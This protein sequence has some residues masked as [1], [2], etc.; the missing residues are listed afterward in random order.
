MKKRVKSIEARDGCL[1]GGGRM[2]ALMRSL[3]WSTTSIGPVENWSAALRMMVRLIL[4]NRLQM[5]LW[6]GPGFCQIYN[7]AAWPALG[8]KHPRS[9]GQPAS[10]CWA[11]IWHII[12]PLI[13]APFKGGEATWMDDIFLEINR[14]GFKEET[15]WTIAYSPV[16]DD[17]APGGIGG[18]IGT[19]NEITGKVLGER[20]IALLRDLGAR[21]SEAKTA[22]EAC[23]VAAQSLDRHRE[24]VPFG[25]IYLIGDDGNT[26]MLAGAS[27]ISANDAA[28][29]HTIDLEA[30][31]SSTQP[32]PLAAS[33]RSEA[34]QLVDDLPARLDGVPP[35]P[36]SDP[37]T[38]AV[39]SPIRSNIAHRLAGVLVL[40]VSARLI[41]DDH[42]RGFFELL[43]SQVANAIANARAYEEE[44]KR[45]EA[46]AEIDRAKTAFFSNVS[47]EFRTPLTLMLGPIEDM[48]SRLGPREEVP[49]DREELDL[50]HRN[51]RRLLKLV[52]TLLDFSRTEA[53]R[54]HAAFEPIDL[55]EL[56]GELASVFRPAI[57]KA[58]LRFIVDCQPLE[59]AVH[60]DRSMWE[61]IA[62]NLLSNAF[63]FT[64]EGE[65][66]LSLRHAGEGVEL[67][68]RDTG[69]GIAEHELP[70]IFDR[71]HR[72]E[73]ARGRTLE[74]SGIGLALVQE[75]AKLHRGTVR[76]ESTPGV[77]SRFTVAVPYGAAD[78]AA[79]AGPQ[80]TSTATGARAYVGEAL[81]WLP[82][83]LR[84]GS[85][86]VAAK[87]PR[88]A[89]RILLA[90]DNADLRP[91][92]ERLLRPTYRVDTA[93]DGE[94]A[95]AAARDDPPDLVLADVM[96]P[97]LD[98]FGLL[99]ALRADPRTRDV[100]LI[101][102]YARAGEESRVDGLAAGANDYLIKPFTARE[103]LAR[104]HSA[105]S[106]AQASRAT[107][108]LERSMRKSAEDARTRTGEELAS[109]LA[110]M[111]RLHELSTRL[112]ADTEL[113]P[114]LEEVLAATIE[115][116]TAD[117]GMVQLYDPKNRL[118]TLV[119]QRGF[120]IELAE[121]F[122]HVDENS[123]TSCG[124]AMN[125]RKRVIIE[126]VLTD[127]AYEPLR[128]VAAEAG[129]RAIQSTPLFSRGGELLGVISTHFVR[130]HRP[131]VRELT[132]TDLYARHAADAIDRKRAQEVLRSSEERFRRYFELG[133]IGMAI[134][135][136]AKGIVEVN[137]ELCN[138]LGYERHELMR[139]T[140]TEMTHPDDLAADVGQFTRVLDGEIDGYTLDK[141][142]I[143]KD[144]CVIHSITAAKC[145]RRHDGTVDYFVG[146][147]QDITE[148]KSAVEDRRRAEEALAGARVDLA[149]IMRVTTMGELVASIAHEINQPLGAIATSGHAGMRWLAAQPPN[150]HEAGESLG[151]IVRDASR[152]ANV[153][154]RIR[155]FLQREPMQCSPIDIVDTIDE[156]VAFLQGAIM[157][158]G[159]SLSITHAPR[160]R[161][162]M[163]DRVQLQ[164]VIVNLVMN[165]IESM[166]GV[167]DRARVL[168]IAATHHDGAML[169]VSVRDSGVGIEHH[170][171]HRIFDAFYTSKAN[172]MGMGLA[173]SRSIIEAHGGRLWLS[174]NAGPG[175]TFQFTLPVAD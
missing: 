56:T 103:L 169:A 34:M 131:L 84:E 150:V 12:G 125:S 60:V 93:P 153:I 63:K 44:R 6:W 163:G 8:A 115:L 67:S 74:G 117:F 94:A 4:A 3:D 85:P 91:Y 152:A 72:I 48:I 73:G 143:R 133:L 116:Q 119:A 52:N 108:Q 58:G 121:R 160:L 95:L 46:L 124:H 2:G 23:A 26:A 137:D 21:S 105:L 53:G 136:I 161:A 40:G 41:F 49:V 61:K 32:W 141:R 57:E 19:V 55:A 38:M 80:Q 70:R 9:M 97:R 127:A 134:T 111:S 7:D 146:L 24:D 120:P 59:R 15:H 35:G 98:G 20:R 10:I 43:T 104:V 39:V 156:A 113:Q 28:R 151:R 54:M 30:D 164:Q 87:S 66:E 112:I 149:R 79:N 29:W 22:A 16:P 106:T 147:V 165:A 154:S 159:V 65:I 42:Y 51:G 77:G 78:A 5:F 96:M 102:L 118:L 140:W 142:W 173:I 101:M 36:W 92:V 31:V 82:E 13:E 158:K 172:G 122:R 162:V 81:R 99:K 17:T 76:A 109:E 45:A 47:H 170:H 75:L 110:A 50:V 130:P 139:M 62:L 107:V 132:L 18:V 86:D 128:P 175:T 11:E 167:N 14:K 129:F 168:S 100:P 138:I 71:F 90:D 126:D 1:V 89:P 64:F 155:G 174:E 88:D 144:G 27:G 148:R 123:P 145:V 37:P 68:V 171:R 25:L 135:S 33:L 157:N 166:C 69:T 114:M 83:E